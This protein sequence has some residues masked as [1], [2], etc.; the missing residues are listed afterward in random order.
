VREVVDALRARFD[1][2][3]EIADHTPERMIFK[4]PRELI[5]DRAA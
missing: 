1:V 4:L 5:S 3:E 2:S